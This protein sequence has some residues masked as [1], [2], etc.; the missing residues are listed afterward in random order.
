[1]LL[2]LYKMEKMHGR[3]EQILLSTL[4]I[5]FVLPF[6]EEASEYWNS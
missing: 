3:H 4:Q 2:K 1:M 5:N 6:G